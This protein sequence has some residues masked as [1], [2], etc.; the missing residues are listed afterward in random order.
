MEVILLENVRNLGKFGNKVKVAKG[1]GRN[2]LIPQGKAVPA[3]KQNIAQFE[4]QRS[5]LEKA[6]QDRLAAATERAAELSAIRLTIA[7][8]SGDEGKLFGSI[9]T[10]ELV[11]A[12]KDKGVDIT[13]QE[14][15]LPNGPLRELGEFVI[16][17]QLHA[18][19]IAQTKVTVVPEEE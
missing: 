5:K 19:V 1:F 3:T 8:R 7:A 2:F 11:R 18:E 12:F 16:E 10:I 6:A 9:G 4:A 14:I 15:K 13:R 17:L